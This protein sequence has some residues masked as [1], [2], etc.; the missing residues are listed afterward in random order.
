MRTRVWAEVS[1]EA[2]AL[3]F[4][5]LTARYG[6]VAAVVKANAYGHGLVPV[7][8]ACVAAG[9][10]RLCVATLDEGLSLRKAGITEA[11]YPLSALLPEEAE[12]CL[13]AHL[14]PFISSPAFF[15]AFATAAQGAPLPAPCF[16]VHDSG[17][18]REGMDSETLAQL[19]ASCPPQV[20][21]VG[22]ATHFASAD[23]PELAP[24][25]AQ[26]AAFAEATRTWQGER[27]LSNSPGMLR[28]PGEGFPRAGAILYGIAPYPGALEQCPVVPAMTVKA[29]LTLV[30]PLPAGATVGYGRTHTLERDSVIA[31]VPAGYGDGWLR[32]LGNQ[33]FVSV[34]GVRCPIV[35]RVSMDQCQ[36]DVTDVPGVEVGETVTLIGEGITAEEVAQWAETTAHEPTTLLNSRVPRYYVTG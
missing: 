20:E 7:A 28:V 26:C 9:A 29:R 5:L 21:I 36:I 30:K 24:T 13:R 10:Q 34:R 27:S 22:V 11:I 4:R 18:G 14:T 16:L 8:R 33:G 17:M 12:D 3:N 23:E 2:I 32:R 25:I 31:T 19:R 1:L 15:Q 35:G 6:D